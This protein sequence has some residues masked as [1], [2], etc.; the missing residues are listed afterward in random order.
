VRT[1]AGLHATGAPV[2]CGFAVPPAGFEPAPPPPER[3]R[4][5]LGGAGEARSSGEKPLALLK[6]LTIDRRVLLMAIDG[7]LRT[8]CGLSADCSKIN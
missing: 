4:R 7:G 8:S 5:W 2:T 3:E 1:D 6:N